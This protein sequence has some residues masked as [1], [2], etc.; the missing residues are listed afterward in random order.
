M[1]FNSGFKGLIKFEFFSIDF[2]KVLKI[3]KFHEISPER[4]EGF[5]TAD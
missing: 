5:F 4:A 2:R 3:I 1:G